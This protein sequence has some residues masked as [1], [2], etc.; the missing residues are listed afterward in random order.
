MVYTYAII[1]HIIFVWEH[2]LSCTACMA[3]HCHEGV[4]SWC[5][6]AHVCGASCLAALSLLETE[7]D[8]PAWGT[9]TPANQQHAK[10][11]STPQISA[12]AATRP[13]QH[14]APSED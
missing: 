8:I 10:Q 7:K 5:P 4:Y 9:D 6:K 11:T 3:M 12:N 13:Y 14:P 1:C 2:M